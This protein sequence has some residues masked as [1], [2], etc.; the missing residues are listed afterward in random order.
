[1]DELKYTILVNNPQG[2][3]ANEENGILP[4][5]YNTCP[6]YVINNNEV[7]LLYDYN[8]GKMCDPIY[9]KKGK[10]INSVNVNYLFNEYKEARNYVNGLNSVLRA[11][12]EI[13]T[14]THYYGESYDKYSC[15]LTELL[16][17]YSR[18]MFKCEEQ[19]SKMLSICGDLI[20]VKKMVNKKDN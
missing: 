3:F 4:N 15:K 18:N 12:V 1:M 10:C 7:V 17:N 9:D 11:R 6:C 8:I 14:Y 2:Y 13:Y 19:E 16:H 5:W 20:D